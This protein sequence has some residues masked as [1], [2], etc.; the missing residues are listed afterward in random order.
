[1]CVSNQFSMAT[2]EELKFHEYQLYSF[3]SKLQAIFEVITSE[4]TYHLNLATLTDVF[5]DDPRMDP[6][7]PEGE[8]VMNRTQHS[9][10]FSNVK[11]I[12]EVS[13]RYVRVFLANLEP[14]S[15]LL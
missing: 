3:L 4:A 10:I 11:E 13:A 15:H 14:I 2:A 5:M 8:K 12:R 1:M 7:R 6:N 9:A